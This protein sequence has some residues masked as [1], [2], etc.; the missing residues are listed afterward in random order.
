MRQDPL[1]V[2]RSRVG[3]PFFGSQA[4]LETRRVS[5]D[6]ELRRTGGRWNHAARTGIRSPP[7]QRGT[8][9]PLRE[10]GTKKKPAA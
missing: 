1:F 7:R 4:S 9:N 2:P 3:F 6:S 5:K 10:Q 8:G